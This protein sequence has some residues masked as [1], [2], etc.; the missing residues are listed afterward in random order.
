MLIIYSEDWLLIASGSAVSHAELSGFALSLSIE[1]AGSEHVSPTMQV[2]LKLKG[3]KRF[4]WM[5]HRL[6]L[7]FERG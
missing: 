6:L 1:I 7:Y 3:T 2:G 5:Q 4:Y